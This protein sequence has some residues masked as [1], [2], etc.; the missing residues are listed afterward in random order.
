MSPKFILAIALCGTAHAATIVDILGTVSGC[1]ICNSPEN[2][3]PG[4]TFAAT[5]L[6][7]PV[8]QTFAAGTYTVT[9]GDPWTGT[10]NTYSAWAF[11]G[12]GNGGNWVWSFVVASVTAGTATILM[13]D[14]ANFTGST[15]AGEAALTGVPDYDGNTLLSS[16][17][18]A[19][20]SDTLTLASATTLYFFIDDYFLPDN[21]GGVALN[22]TPVGS[23]VPEPSSFIPLGIA[24]LGLAAFGMLRQ[25]TV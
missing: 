20:F 2:I 22:I 23:S 24:L 25:P 13:D 16:T 17:S 19:G 7:S 3:L 5:G 10:A 4:T 21:A 11:N 9:N 15:Q 6:Q 18:V 1:N 8:T 12:N 14:Y